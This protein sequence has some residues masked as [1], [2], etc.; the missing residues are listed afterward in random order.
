MTLPEIHEA[1]AL[2]GSTTTT[3]CAQISYIMQS[4]ESIPPVSDTALCT[5]DTALLL[6]DGET[7]AIPGLVL[8]L[9][10]ACML[11]DPQ[12]LHRFSPLGFTL[13]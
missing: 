12:A 2:V 11:K 6:C 9:A 4:S 1:V 3:T 13:A 10:V 7:T 8:V 5:L